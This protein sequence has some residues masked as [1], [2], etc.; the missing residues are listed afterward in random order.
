[1]QQSSLFKRIGVYTYLYTG[2]K[3]WEA[4]MGVIPI[5]ED[6]Y[7]PDMGHALYDVEVDGERIILTVYPTNEY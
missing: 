7:R 2:P 5:F 1:M 3:D 4:E 6:Y